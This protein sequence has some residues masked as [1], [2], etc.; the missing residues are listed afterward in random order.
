MDTLYIVLLGL[1]IIIGLGTILGSFFTVN[2]AQA[3]IV[4]R[5]GRFLPS[6]LP[7]PAST[8]RLP[9]SIRSRP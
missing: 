7:R 2:T 9:I 5:F 1:I 3:A 6:A 4:T 8:G